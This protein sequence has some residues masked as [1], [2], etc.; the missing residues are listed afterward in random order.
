[1]LVL[2]VA[3]ALGVLTASFGVHAVAVALSDVHRTTIAGAIALGVVIQILRA[4]RARY[5]LAQKR[6]ITLGDSYGAM[7]VSHGI[8]DLLPLAPAGP[9]LRSTLTQ[10]FTH[11]PIAFS[12]GVFMLEGLLDGIGPALLV[13]YLFLAL[14]LPLWVRAIFGV[15]LAQ[16]ALVVIVPA[17][18]GVAR[19][20]FPQREGE[21]KWQSLLRLADGLADGLGILLIGP[22]I[23]VRAVGFSL[24]ITAAGALQAAL[25]LQ[26]FELESSITHLCLLFILT[27]AAGSVPIKIPGFGTATTAAF[28]PVAGIH[29]AGVAG[30]ILI[31]RLI[32]SAQAPVLAAGVVGWWTVRQ[33]LW[34]VHVG[35]S[36]SPPA[37]LPP[38][39]RGA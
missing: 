20:F 26:A 4:Q 21:S 36:P 9:L 38:G 1:M 14:S 28:L 35:V 18:A 13:S 7:V 30:F 6:E 25:F 2:S 8:G 34:P 10:R 23:A 5:L 12:S 19:R 3:A 27:M 16:L 37:P 24:L 33:R 39:E 29:G 31:T 15:I 17:L 22:G 32:S 11:I